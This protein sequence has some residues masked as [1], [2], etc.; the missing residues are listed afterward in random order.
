MAACASGAVLT[1]RDA[2][3]DSRGDQASS[4]CPGA[5]RA[6]LAHESCSG[7]PMVP[8]VTL[9]GTLARLG[10]W[11]QAH[12]A[13]L[14]RE[15]PRC[16]EAPEGNRLEVEGLPARARRWTPSRHPALWAGAV[17]ARPDAR[18]HHPRWALDWPLDVRPRISIWACTPIHGSMARARRMSL[19]TS[20]TVRIGPV[21]SR[22][23]TKA[24]TGLVVWFRV[25]RSS[26]LP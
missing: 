1:S 22:P 6:S 21:S 9:L 7:P 23:N 18:H 8:L 24:A 11:D 2:H 20:A 19:P 13:G 26:T 4:F 3:A 15:G 5:H 17:P 14:A 16:G 12:A 10:T 25:V